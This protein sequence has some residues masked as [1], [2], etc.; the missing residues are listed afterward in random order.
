VPDASLIASLVYGCLAAGIATTKD[1]NPIAWFVFGTLSP[2]VSILVISA[3]P[4][5]SVWEIEIASGIDS[6]LRFSTR[7]C[8]TRR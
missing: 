6:Q 8:A 3:L 5:L 1:R 7:D 2:L 4:R